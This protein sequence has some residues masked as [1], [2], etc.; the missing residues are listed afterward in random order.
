M[1]TGISLYMGDDAA[2]ND[3]QIERARRAG[4]R[5]AFT[6]LQI[7]EEQGTAYRT[8]A[9]HLLAHC[10]DAGIE[11]MVDVSP[12]TLD[13]LGCSRLEDLRELGVTMVRLDFG[14]DAAQTV[15]L[16]RTFRI[17][18]NASTVSTDDI[19]AWRAAG[20]DFSRF[21]ACHNFYPKR[22]TGLSLEAVRRI[23]A[24]LSVLGFTTMAFI[25]GDERQRGPLFEGLPTVEEHRREPDR[26][27]EHALE[28]RAASTDIVL[29]GDPGLSQ[30][31]W[32]TWAGLSHDAVPLHVTLDEPFAE[33]Y[34]QTH[35][36][37]P[38]SSAW[39]F[40]S[41]ESRGACK[42]DRVPMPRDAEPAQRAAGCIAVANERYGRYAGE[43][44][45]A[46]VDLPADDRQTVAG[47]VCAEDL[48]LLPHLTC[49]MGV[50]L[51]R[52]RG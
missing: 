18:F 23:N 46:R 9:Q 3:E 30:E 15:E 35:H 38:D 5:Y 36:D 21:A 44:E 14:F 45:I 34:G 49:G 43:L 40:R 51:E 29:V 22:F 26:I 2:Y 37:R 48:P 8:E 24:R 7:P 13:N 42:M 41:V 27:A 6:S 17:V 10:H 1:Q 12:A 19:R 4:V 39:V 50:T 28:L 47:A 11:L 25:P 52:P 31:G 20:A 33:L 32:T 16:S